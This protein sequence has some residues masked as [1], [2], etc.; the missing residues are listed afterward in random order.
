MS[1]G[2]FR[3]HVSPREGGFLYVTSSDLPGFRVLTRAESMEGD[4][5]E[6]FGQFYPLWTASEAMREA[7]LPPRRLRIEPVGPVEANAE[8]D[9]CAELLSE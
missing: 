3:L 4:V 1:D 8:Y 7:R 5:S 6:A 9:V 2:P